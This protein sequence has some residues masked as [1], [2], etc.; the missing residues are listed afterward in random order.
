MK[1]RRLAV[2]REMRALVDGAKAAQRALT[3]DERKTYDELD[4]E[5]RGIDEMIAADERLGLDPAAA[6]GAD[7]AAAPARSELRFGRP[8]PR[9]R[10]LAE[11]PGVGQATV[12]EAGAYLRN[13][14]FDRVDKRALG[15]SVDAA[16]G[17]AVPA[18]IAGT[19]LDLVRRRARVIEA[20]A[21][22]VPMNSETLT[23]AKLVTD[24]APSWTAENVQIPESDP[25]FGA[26]TFTARGLKVV[27]RMSRELLEDA[28]NVE[29]ALTNA[30]VQAY[31]LELDRAALY[32]AGGANVPLGLRNVAGL[33]VVSLGANG[34]APTNYGFLSR[35]IQRVKGRN[36]SPTGIILAVR[37]EGDLANLTATD[38]QPLVPS[39]Y[40]AA[41][42]RYDT[43][44]IPTNQAIGTG[45]NASEAFVGDFSRLH[46]G[47]RTSFS[48]LPLRE[49]YADFGQV[50][51]V[52]WLRADVQVSR[53]DAFSVV[54]GILATA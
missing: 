23:T 17:F 49:R 34:A 35:A 3:P 53:I 15:E 9:D 40:V 12:E 44:Q 2:W 19:I 32:G 21:E 31:A 36:Y 24:P 41:V 46:I 1:E 6:A 4:A 39:P 43:T 26:L 27:T 11:L 16:G 29:A 20:G 38:G 22:V 30:L 50:G 33:E 54:N 48:I 7:A 28:P 18:P 8:L 25:A 47:L 14:L 51:F 37:T 45:T 10:S 52:G 42:P 13:L 5:L